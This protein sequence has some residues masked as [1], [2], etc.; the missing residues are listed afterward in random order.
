MSVDRG[1]QKWILICGIAIFVF[2]L[3]W[4]LQWVMSG[5]PIF[6]WRGIMYTGW[7]AGF[8]ISAMCA[9]GLGL[10]LTSLR[11]LESR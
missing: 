4:A 2:G 1:T 9:I 7:V 5:K 8:V 6:Y 10:V 3:D 11:N